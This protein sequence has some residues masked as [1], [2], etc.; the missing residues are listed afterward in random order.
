[1]KKQLLLVMLCAGMFCGTEAKGQE[2]ERLSGYVQAERFTKEKLNTM[3]FSTSVDPHWFRK[4]SSFWYEYKTGN[5]KVWYVV[6]PVAKTKRPLF[7]LDDIAAQITEI[8]KDP[9][10]AQQLPIQKLEAGEDGR[11]F[12]FQITSSQEAKKDSTDKDKGPKKEI[13]FFSYDYPTRKLTWLKEKKKETEYPDWASFSPDG[14]TVVYAKDLNLYR[15]SRED[16]EKLKKDDKDSTVTDIQLTTFGVKDFGFG[17]PYSLLNTDTLCNGK[18]KGVWGIVWSPDSR[19]FA[20]TVEDERAVK[21]LWVINSMASPRPTLETYKYQMPG[22]KEA[23]VRHLFLFDMNDN[24]Y[25]EIRTSAFKDQTL[26][27]ARRPWRQKDRD[28][29]EVASVWLGDN[30]RFFVTRSSRDLHRIDICSYTV[31]QDSICPIIEERM[32]TYQEVR[33]LAAVGDGK[34]LIQWSE[35]DGWAHLY[36]YDG[37][38]NLKNRITRGPWHVDQ[39]VK[40]DEAKRVVYFLANGKEKDEN[41]YYEH[42]YRVG[43]DGSGLQQVTPGDYFHTV[44]MD[45]NAAFV[46]NNY[47]RVNTIPRTDLMD[48]NG[49]KLM[50]L[51]ESDFSGLLA[52]GYQF[53]EPFKVKAA[54]G[55]T[56]LYGVMYKPFN[57]DSTALYPIIDYVYPGPQV[58]ATVYPFSRM[59]VRTDRLAQAGF[60]VITVG[61]RGG[62]P[63]RSK[64]YHNFGYG[65][66]RDYG[67]ADQKAAIEQLANRYSFIDINRVGIHGHSGGGFMSTAAILQYPDFFKAAVSCAGNHDNR[68][69]NRW[70]SETHHG[71]KEVVSEKGDTTFV[72]NIK[73]N[74]EIASRLKGHLMLVHGDI[75]NNVHPGNT[76]RVADALIR[77]GKR[78]DM[79]LLPQQRHGFGDMDEYFYWRMVDYFSRHLLG[80]QETSVDI[81]KRNKTKRVRRISVHSFCFIFQDSVFESV[82]HWL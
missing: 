56:D 39:I 63:S 77:A 59:S 28:R 68:I 36:L 29:K 55:V 43:L 8:V 70:W 3:L 61:N 54:D 12:T 30:N 6:D 35:R 37:E 5:G 15:M 64:W 74:E 27:L 45:D 24:S 57:F 46:V 48:S 41:P 1:M 69:Y 82:F 76:L 79:L 31:G 81:P 53:P 2:A 38:G 14:K 25:K 16:Y 71:V 67:L 4:G 66:L 11:T 9:F 75:D 23:P 60:I 49:R 18:R 20:V 13:F 33:P 19:Y 34:E 51:E 40:V 32:N 7:D 62:H 10:T 22:E 65:N 50:T 21:D 47:S 17:Q 26:R 73:T 44:S 52:A 42:L 78:F 80:E 58:E 72:Y